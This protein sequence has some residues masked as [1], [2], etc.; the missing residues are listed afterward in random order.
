MNELPQFVRNRLKAQQGA[1]EHPDADMLNAFA[2][3]VLTG[4]ERER[5]LAHLSVCAECREIVALVSPEPQ[6]TQPAAKPA[7]AWLSFPVLKWGVIAAS[8]IVVA[9]AVML[10]DRRQ[11]VLP[12]ELQVHTRPAP[13][14]ANGG[15][16]SGTSPETSKEESRATDDS[17]TSESIAKEEARADQSR[18]PDSD[19]RSRIA[20]ASAEDKQETANPLG[21]E[22]RPM[23]PVVAQQRSTERPTAFSAGA[24]QQKVQSSPGNVE[25][26]A[27]AAPAP[28]PGDFDRSQLRASQQRE[29]PT[30]AA[31]PAQSL[32]TVEEPDER[33]AL[34]RKMIDQAGY[35]NVAIPDRAQAHD[36]AKS[37]KSD[38]HAVSETVEVTAAAPALAAGFV[39]PAPARFRVEEGKLLR[40]SEADG[41]WQPVALPPA[42]ITSFATRGTAVWAAGRSG[43]LFRSHNAGRT[44]T[45]VPVVI[46]GKPLES[47]IMHVEIDELGGVSL[48]DAEGNVWHSYGGRDWRHVP[49]K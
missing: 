33:A 48:F 38:R 43:I 7:R 12:A 9:A 36:L 31:P 24:Q 23:P 17:T 20:K 18:T 14:P 4:R 49:S 15:A 21:G 30:Q 34:R 27:A 2:E 13:S 44:W 3:H 42:F 1:A 8:I 11:E 29:I 40:L 28:P 5:V 6:L 10:R 19:S 25:G 16:Q 45:R 47:D 22:V 41:A 46:N 39:T 37:Q 26:I 35:G 32:N